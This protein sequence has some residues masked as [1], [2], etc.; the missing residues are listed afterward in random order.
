[1]N[2]TGEK[3]MKVLLKG[4]MFF[5]IGTI[6]AK[7]LSYTYR[8][9]IARSLSVED[10]GTFNLVITVAAIAALIAN[11][12]LSQGME[13]FL[14]Y[15]SQD[16]KR[17]HTIIT[18]AL[19]VVIPLSILIALLIAYF[20]KDIAVSFFHAEEM[21]VLIKIIAIGIPFYT[22][23]ELNEGIFKGS[24]NL[25]YQIY[26][27]DIIE[28]LIRL[29]ITILALLLGYQ[30]MGVVYAYIFSL[31]ASAITGYYIIRK[32]IL[33][34]ENLEKKHARSLQK[35]IMLFSWPAMFTIWL[36]TATKW[37]DTLLL[38]FLDT[39]TNVGLY[40]AALPIAAA[41]TIIYTALGS[42]LIPVLSELHKNN[43]KN[44]LKELFV[45]INRW[46][47]IVT[48]P[49]FLVVIL[50]PH[51]V[52]QLLF[53]E[54]Y[55]AAA[56]ALIILALGYFFGVM[57]GQVGALMNVLGKTKERMIIWLS[58]GIFSVTL[59]AL[60][61]YKYGLIGAAIA[62]ALT[63]FYLNIATTLYLWK[64]HQVRNENRKLIK[65]FL[66][67]ILAMIPLFIWLRFNPQSSGYA[68]AIAAVLSGT[69]YLIIALL[70][71]SFDK[72]DVQ[73][74]TM[75]ENKTGYK[76]TK[77]KNILEKYT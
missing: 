42:L 64:Y 30:L 48:L 7:I 76:M 19:K 77:I 59:N 53:G 66:A 56:S 60:L 32:K 68:F 54:K 50:F 20:S 55:L 8:A 73:L 27:S 47:V 14:G 17:T 44:L 11:L 45:R 62:T 5:L 58:G 22:I 38:G 4:T 10:F 41:L 72:E 74:M 31:M 71:R 70:I 16:K 12:G 37:T 65:P 75:L 6:I 18:F 24:K 52:I 46:G 28:N 34:R 33:P 21:A 36:Y 69:L 1:M 15:F 26:T 9:I 63:F 25:K 29:T 39:R 2:E 23:T 35:E 13:R 67:G 51:Q 61:I 43:E 49:I 3:A 40:N 57:C